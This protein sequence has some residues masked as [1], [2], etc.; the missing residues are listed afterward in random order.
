MNI[1]FYS[2]HMDT[3]AVLMRLAEKHNC[4]IRFGFD[5]SSEREIDEDILEKYGFTD[6]LLQE[7]NDQMIIR[8]SQSTFSKVWFELYDKTRN[9]TNTM[10]YIQSSTY[11][12]VEKISELEFRYEYPSNELVE[13]L[14]ENDADWDADNY[15]INKAHNPTIIYGF[16]NKNRVEDFR[17]YRSGMALKYFSDLVCDY[18]GEPRIDRV[19]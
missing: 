7:M 1:E 16:G 12:S 13:W 17:V 4:C 3:F 5:A 8:D 15:I 14:E 10:T 9:T 2:N 18:L 19:Y 11:F 6:A